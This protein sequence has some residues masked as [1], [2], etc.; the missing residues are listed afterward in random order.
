MIVRLDEGRAIDASIPDGRVQ[1]KRRHIA[2]ATLGNALEFYDFVTYAFFAIQIGHAFFPGRGGYGSLMLSLAT[3]GAG[4]ITRPIGALV[5]GGYADKVGRRP[6][7]VLSFSLMG[8]AIIAMAI[9]PPYAAIGIAAPLLAIT[10]R[11]VQGFS[12]GG[13]IGANTAFL[14]EAAA[15]EKRGVIVAWQGASQLIAVTVGSLVGWALTEILPA[16]GL[17][18]YGWRLAFLLGAVTLPIGLWLRR[19]IPETLHGGGPSAPEESDVSR[20]RLAGRSRRVIGLGIVILGSATIGTYI[21]DYIVTF[22]QDSLHLSARI[23]FLAETAGNL[24]GIPALLMGAALSDRIGRWRI[25]VWTNLALLILIV[26]IFWVVVASRS[27]VVLFLAM[28]VLGIATNFSSGSYSVAI[29]ESLPRSIRGGGFGTVYSIAIAAFGGTTQLVVTWLIHLTGSALAP[30][31]YL[32]I[33]TG[34]GQ[35]ALMLFPESAPR[36]VR[37]QRLVYDAAGAPGAQASTIAPI[38]G[39]MRSK[40]ASAGVP[41]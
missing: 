9:I 23:G 39:R 21:L 22:A 16:A 29:A 10:A 8:G 7:M 41:R 24:L 25:N 35:V 33:A 32:V 37:D 15:P 27:P 17:D 5:I 40:G 3:F 36:L 38:S 34:I 11:M 26:P 4:F 13:E 19:A 2:A 28:A 6:A 30:A 1:L 20:W 14:L 12:L 31:G 18:A